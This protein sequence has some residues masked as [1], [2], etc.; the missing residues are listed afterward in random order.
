MILARP[1]CRYPKTGR[2][3]TLA[4]VDPPTEFAG[5][6]DDR[7]AYQVIGEG[8]VDLVLVRGMFSSM[9]A[10]WAHPEVAAVHR[11]LS[12]FCRLILFD[13]RGTGASDAV[14]LEALPPLEARWAEIR[15]VMDAAGSERSVL[16]GTQDGGP[17]AML[18]AAS[19]PSRVGGLILF[20]SPARFVQADDYPIGMRAED[21]DH[22]LEMMAAWDIEAMLKMS[23]PSRQDDERFLQFLRVSLRA[24][25]TPDA[26]LVYLREMM[27]T[28]VRDLL[29][30][31][32]V[33]T[34][35][36]HRRD[37]QVQEIELGRY[38]ADH[39]EGARFVEVPGGDADIFFDATDDIIKVIREFLAEIEPTSQERARVD[40][41]MATVLLTDIVSSTTRAQELGDPEWVTLLRLHDELTRDVVVEHGGRIVKTT[42]DGVLAIFDGPGRGL[43]CASVLSPTLARAGLPI[44]AGIHTGE[45]ERRGEDIGGIGVHIAARVMAV[46]KA[47]EILVSRTVRDLVVGSEFRFEDRGAYTLKGVEG[48]WQLFALADV[49]TAAPTTTDV[50]P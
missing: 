47:G 21:A 26:L 3:T 19:D 43:L 49:R 1:F 40:R 8:P 7:I 38:A 18:G 42:G 28:D 15:A 6:G 50:L 32:R 46:A 29:A 25:A 34:L 5:L 13:R 23:F 20:H 14:T 33:P 36:M 27:R 9:D 4:D 45:V 30:L 24:A 16:M 31:I 2:S 12:T 39:I 11:R 48:D 35:V 41:F 44:R 37:Y 17:P 22:W 10:L